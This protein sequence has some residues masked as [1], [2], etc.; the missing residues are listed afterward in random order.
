MVWYP[1]VDDVVDVNVGVVDATRNKHPHGL[2]V[3][4]LAIESVL[5]RVRRVE[6]EGTI[7]QAAQL[8]RELVVLHPFAGAN[9]RT[10]YIVVKLFLRRNGRRP[11][12]AR[13]EGAY[14]FIGDL[15]TKTVEEIEEWLKH[16]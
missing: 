6:S 10:A 13:L 15:E 1:S 11:R 5:E 3:S 7:R 12:I 8:M 9:H 4:P 14:A 16:G 2:L